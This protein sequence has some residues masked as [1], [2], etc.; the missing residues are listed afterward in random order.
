MDLVKLG[1]KGQVTIPKGILRKLAIPDEAPLVVEAS[2][3]GAIIL[4]HAV[5]FPIE[6]YDETRVK[7]FSETAKITAREEARME[8]ALKARKSKKR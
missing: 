8:T 3:D 7:E 1:K 5:V 4:R 2:A 6:I